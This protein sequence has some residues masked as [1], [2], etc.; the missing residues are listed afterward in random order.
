MA[1]TA[2]THAR[3]R[4]H[5]A[6]AAHPVA[7]AHVGGLSMRTSCPLAKIAAVAAKLPD[8]AAA[9]CDWLENSSH[10]HRQTHLAS[11]QAAHSSSALADQVSKWHVAESTRYS[12][13]E[14]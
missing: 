3:S 10:R 5:R 12:H 13:I 14:T 1:A 2:A 4:P 6:P 8:N 7:V 11:L 9:M